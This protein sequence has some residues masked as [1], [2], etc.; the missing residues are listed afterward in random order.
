MEEEKA[1]EE[2]SSQIKAKIEKGEITAEDLKRF[3]ENPKM[4]MNVLSWMSYGMKHGL[5]LIPPNHP[6]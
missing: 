1:I 2:L 6:R 5:C 3:L 4:E